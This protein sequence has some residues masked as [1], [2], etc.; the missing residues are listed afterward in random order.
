MV[1]QMDIVVVQRL[2]VLRDL[3]A[4][5]SCYQIQL[6]LLN[7]LAA[8]QLGHEVVE[9]GLGQRPLLVV[10][11]EKIGQLFKNYDQGP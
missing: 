8:D 2:Y 9:L 5:D 3:Y 10:Q 1:R 7:S 6:F 11:P 4:L